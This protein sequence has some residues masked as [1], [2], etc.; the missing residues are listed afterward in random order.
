MKRLIPILATLLLMIS[1]THQPPKKGDV[2]FQLED[3]KSKH[4]LSPRY[5]ETLYVPIYANVYHAENAQLFPLTTTLSLRNMS[6]VDSVF[7]YAIDYYSTKGEVIRRYI[8]DKQML[9]LGPLES[10]DLVTDKK[11][12]V[13]GTGDNYIVKWG[14]LKGDATL[15]VEA[16]MVSTSGQQG[17]SFVTEGKIIECDK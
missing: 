2:H 7:V 1:C 10:Y 3:L 13:K 12:T 15:L 8:K 5:M 17:L 16:V 4:V 9:A 11:V 6:M 14:R